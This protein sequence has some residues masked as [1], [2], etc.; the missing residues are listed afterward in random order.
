MDTHKKSGQDVAGAEEGGFFFGSDTPTLEI[1][2][3]KSLAALAKEF[4]QGKAFSVT[5][6]TLPLDK[7][8]V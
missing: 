7:E 5:E 3:F 2:S 1:E 4:S 6:G 8:D